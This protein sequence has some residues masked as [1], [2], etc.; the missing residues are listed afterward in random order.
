MKDMEA[1]LAELGKRE[2]RAYTKDTPHLGKF[3]LNKPQPCD[4]RQYPFC[5][6]QTLIHYNHLTNQ[7]VEPGTITVRCTLCHS[8]QIT[9]IDQWRR[10]VEKSKKSR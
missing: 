6:R 7:S 1:K 8:Y 5:G 3:V 4:D 9:T 2:R 10:D